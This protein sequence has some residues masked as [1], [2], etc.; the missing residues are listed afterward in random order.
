MRQNTMH[1]EHYNL[2]LF[3]H[4]LEIITSQAIAK[5]IDANRIELLVQQINKTF[6]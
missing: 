1:E 5:D 6:I 2:V 3:R 4:F